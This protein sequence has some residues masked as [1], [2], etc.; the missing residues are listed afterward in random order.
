[1]QFVMNRSQTP[2]SLR[3]RLYESYVSTHA[4]CSSAG[5]AAIAYRSTVRPH[6]P[7]N[8]HGHRVLDIGCGQG[9]LVRLLDDDGFEARGIDIS[10]EQVEF[11]HK[12]GLGQVEQGD[13]HEHLG[14]SPD[15][16]DAVVATDVLE[17]LHK[18]EVLR[19]FD[20]VHKG[21]KPGGVFVARVPNAVSPV[22]GNVMYSDVTHETWFTRRSVA[23]LAA[24]AGF[25][26]TRTYP[27]S[28]VAHGITSAARVLIWKVASGLLKL[29]L[30]AETGELRGHITTQN[31]V[32]VARKDRG[33]HAG[34]PDAV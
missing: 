5:A 2:D 1:M 20:D 16:W 31:L 13:F 12:A 21:L 23:Q 7:A 15:R 4:G 28:P 6:L 18:D 27:C 24:V 9:G 17:H 8:A 25:E 30:A 14:S 34:Q 33:V 3:E 11:A 32:F 19:T 10:P 26:S 22:G 29:T